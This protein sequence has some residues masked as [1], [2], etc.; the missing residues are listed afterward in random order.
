M[1]NTYIV[2][3]SQFKPYTFDE[4]IKPALMYKQAYEDTEKKLESLNELGIDENSFLEQDAASR[5]VYNNYMNQLQQT[6]DA[7]SQGYNANVAKQAR[8]LHRTFKTKINPMKTK[9]AVRAA[10]TEE[11]RKLQASNPYLEFSKDY[12]TASLDD[13]TE[14]STYKVRDLSKIS[15]EVA[16]DMIKFV[17][18]MSPEFKQGTIYGVGNTLTTKYGYTPEDVYREIQT[19]GSELNKK[20]KKYL[21]K[22]G[23][24]SFDS[25]KLKTV[26]ENT[27]MSNAGVSD[28]QFIKDSKDSTKGGYWMTVGNKAYYVNSNGTVQLEADTDGTSMTNVTKFSGGTGGGDN[29]VSYKEIDDY[30]YYVDDQLGLQKE[31]I[32]AFTKKE[33]DKWFNTGHMVSKENLKSLP[34][35]IKDEIS[36]Y[37]EGTIIV[38]KYVPKDGSKPRY[39][40]RRTY[41]NGIMFNDLNSTQQAGSTPSG[42]A[43][44]SGVVVQSGA[45]NKNNVDSK[46]IG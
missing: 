26:I 23:D 44:T 38:R 14:T 5:E 32:E 27:M 10:L 30:V 43:A 8:D 12:S 21:D 11:Q 28:T 18:S 40:L 29:N 20:F 13:I 1:A 7:L 15:E 31:T 39:V 45:G 36:R 35:D 41:N 16:K 42:G 19:E 6:A 17:A 9:L 25:S 46:N 37:P 34:Q 22:Y 33:E 3:G 24:S 2:S 4:M